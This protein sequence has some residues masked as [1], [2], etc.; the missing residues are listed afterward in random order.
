MR[1]A[2]VTG[3]TGGLGLALT[4]ALL[5]EGYAVRATGRSP[6][7]GARLLTM[8]AS[9]VPAEL[10]APDAAPALV[11]GVDVVFHAAALSS[12]WGKREV[13]EEINIG[14]TARLLAA[15]RA[16][17]CNRFIFI[18]TPSIYCEPRDR[19]HLTEASPVARHFANAY[20][21]TKFAAEQFVI[22]R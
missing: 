4:E 3:A 5:A 10:T 20:A 19:L 21:A 13:F 1:R 16:A 8:G 15:A 18:S 14:A 6:A 22:E 2:L 12:P 7:A 9:F 17:R 11:A